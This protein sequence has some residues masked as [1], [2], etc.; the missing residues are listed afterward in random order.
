[1]SSAEFTERIALGNIEPDG[2]EMDNWR[3]GVIVSG[4]CNAV[5][6]TIPMPKGKKRPKPLTPEDFYPVMAE[7]P[8]LSE[9]QIQELKER[10]GKR[11]HRNR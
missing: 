5:I 7:R 6:A 8:R 2:W 4:I 3:M 10:R 9:R 1:M 11:R